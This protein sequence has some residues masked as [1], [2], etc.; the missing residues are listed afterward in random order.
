MFKKDFCKVID[1]RLKNNHWINLQQ[2]NGNELLK[3]SQKMQN[4]KYLGVNQTDTFEI[5]M[6]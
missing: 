5:W 2:P 3:K 4:I 6:L 1:T